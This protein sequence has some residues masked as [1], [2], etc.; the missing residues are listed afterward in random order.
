[1]GRVF[2]A[3]GAP[4][5]AVSSL[6]YLGRMLSFTDEN[7]PAVDWNIWRGLRKWEQLEKI[8][9]REGADKRMTGRFYVAL[10]QAVL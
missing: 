3:Y 8:L 5:R 7:W 9:V 4:L 2:S 1:M 6:C 10:V